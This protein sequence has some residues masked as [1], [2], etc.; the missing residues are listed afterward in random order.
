MAVVEE[1]LAAPAWARGRIARDAIGARR[2]GLWLCTAGWA[3]MVA[4]WL[5]GSGEL[6]DHDQEG[7]ATVAGVGLF[8]VGWTVM[9]AAMMLPSS[10]PTLTRADRAMQGSRRAGPR[11]L[12]GYFL[13]WTAFGAAT[14]AGDGMLHLSVAS[15]PW[16]AERPSLVLGAAA[17][18]AGVAQVMGHTPSPSL[19]AVPAGTAPFSTGKAHAVDRIRRCWPMMLFAMAV[20][21]SSPAWMVA[22]TLVMTLELVAAA[23][24]ASR[25]AGPIL[26]AL[27]AAVVIEPSWMPLVFGAA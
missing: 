14:F 1:Q 20:G 11:F 16:L 19:P 10:L 8:L 15:V 3:A 17:M 27:G 18:F 4:M 23:R 26:L 2:L 6:F 5:T 7:I 24:A 25:V 13:A 22:L 12:L 9:V 21:M